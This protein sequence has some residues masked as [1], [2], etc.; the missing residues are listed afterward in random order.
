MTH[1]NDEAAEWLV[2]LEDTEH[3]ASARQ[4][5][6][7]FEWLRR[8]PQ[9]VKA[10]FETAELWRGLEG[11]DPQRQVDLEKLLAGRFSSVTSLAG[12]VMQR[13]EHRPRY[14]MLAAAAAALGCTLLLGWMLLRQP[15]A[16]STAVGEQRIFKLPDGSILHLN[17]R[18]RAQVRY[19]KQQRDIELLQGEALFT[20]EQDT[21]RPFLVH[22]RSATIR[23]IGTRFNVL[24]SPSGTQ[25]S[26]VEGTVQVSSG[27]T[28][29]LPAQ[30][31]AGEEAK[32]ADGQV[33]KRRIPD[34][35]AAVTWPERRLVFNNV[36]LDE[37]AAEFNRYNTMQIRT[38]GDVGQSKRL[39]G[40]F[41]ADHPQSLILYLQREP[42]LAVEQRGKTY[43]VTGRSRSLE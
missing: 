2:R 38:D 35:A 33:S 27:A 40:I 8:S 16:Y 30:L 12:A 28:A 23:A 7:F 11:F 1:I 37:V 39:T 18:S 31:A 13:A 41:S 34:M 3:P 32:V 42:A 15:N 10:F 26:V 19:T 22:T 29:S 25:V 20:V 5:A 36:S 6:E 17:T 43:F 21:L 4:Q 14:R 9:H 24:E